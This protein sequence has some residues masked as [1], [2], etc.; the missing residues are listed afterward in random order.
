MANNILVGYDPIK[1]ETTYPA[2]SESNCEEMAQRHRWEL[3]RVEPT[4]DKLLA[5]RCVF[6]GKVSFYQ[7]QE[8][9]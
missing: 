4:N 1:D 5:V 7:D 6:Q 8:N 3:K 2:V 9:E